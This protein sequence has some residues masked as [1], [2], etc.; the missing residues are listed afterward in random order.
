MLSR[1]ASAQPTAL[2]ATPSCAVAA[3]PAGQSLPFHPTL[4][5]PTPPAVPSTLPSRSVAACPPSPHSYSLTPMHVE[6]A[7]TGAAPPSITTPPPSTSTPSCRHYTPTPALNAVAMDVNGPLLVETP[8]AVRTH[9]SSP[10][11]TVIGPTPTTT[12]DPTLRCDPPISLISYA[13][14]STH[15]Q[16]GQ[17]QQAMRNVELQPHTS[18]ERQA[19]FGPSET[20]HT[21]RASMPP[22]THNDDPFIKVTTGTLSMPANDG[23]NYDSPVHSP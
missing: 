23:M 14:A 15:T 21:E 6:D 13:Q 9:R 16:S 3:V 4:A 18:V 1:S 20:N 11:V 8:M 17:S 19:S 5:P 22:P 10:E 7:T 2:S 12:Q